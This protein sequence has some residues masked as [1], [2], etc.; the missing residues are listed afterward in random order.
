MLRI[1]IAVVAIAI[2]FVAGMFVFDTLQSKRRSRAVLTPGTA[3][4]TRN[5]QN[6]ARMLSLI[7][8]DDMVVLPKEREAEVRALL[9]DFYDPPPPPLPPGR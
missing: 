3:E 9:A 7:I 5:H 8:E 4:N 6:M 1:V 2:P